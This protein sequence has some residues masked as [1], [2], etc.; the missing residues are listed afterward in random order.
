MPLPSH[1]AWCSLLAL[2]LFAGC[3]H[4]ADG[5]CV[6]D[7]SSVCYTYRAFDLEGDRLAEGY[8]RLEMGAETEEGTRA[9][10]G[11]WRIDRVGE[12]RLGPQ[13]GAGTLAGVM[14]GGDLV[15][16]LNPELLDGGVELAGT[17]VGEAV[18]GVWVWARQADSDVEGL[19]EARQQD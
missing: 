6:S 12:G 18:S 17:E 10:V 1:A 19:F 14:R 7:A 5:A 13:V 8:L 9:V 4:V 15:V 2:A 3:D 16:S 11:T